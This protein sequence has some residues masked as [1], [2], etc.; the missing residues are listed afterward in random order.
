MNKIISTL[1]L[2]IF[3]CIKQENINA[4][5]KSH[6]FICTICNKQVKNITAHMKTHKGEKPYECTY[7]DKKFSEKCNCI[8]H[9]ALHGGQN[10]EYTCN[11][12]NRK[13]INQDNYIKHLAKHTRNYKFKCD[14]CNKLFM[15]KSNLVIHKRNYHPIIEPQ[16]Y[17]ELEYFFGPNSVSDS[18]N[19]QQYSKLLL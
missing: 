15:W 1:C 12:C 17:R 4:M 7:C 14:E 9:I 3:L 11:L 8:R 10:I 2:L 18:F 6:F 13:C 5:K 19:Y 16:F